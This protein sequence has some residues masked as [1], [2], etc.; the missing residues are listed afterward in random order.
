MKFKFKKK[1]FSG[2]SENLTMNVNAFLKLTFT[3]D[4]H[5][6][7]LRSLLMMALTAEGKFDE[8]IEMASETYVGK[9]ST[10]PEMNIP[11]IEIAKCL[12]YKNIIELVSV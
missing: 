9:T 7:E 8:T 5:D 11:I 12:E 10:D 1:M 2:D 3:K 4:L 6:L